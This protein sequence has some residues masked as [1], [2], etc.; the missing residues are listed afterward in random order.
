MIC[1][2]TLNNP[3]RVC[4]HNHHT[5]PENLWSTLINI[6]EMKDFV[7]WVTGKRLESKIYVLPLDNIYSSTGSSEIDI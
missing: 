4:F 3:L 5:V 6:L 2:S 1:H 7:L